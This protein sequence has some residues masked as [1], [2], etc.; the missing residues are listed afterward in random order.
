[1]SKLNET[2]QKVLEHMIDGSLAAT[3]GQFG[4]IDELSASKLDLDPQA[5][6]AYITVLQEKGLVEVHTKDEWGQQYNILAAGW[7]LTTP[8]RNQWADFS[9]EE[10]ADVRRIVKGGTG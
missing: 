6:G 9:D 5:F 2:E 4:H 7:V 10:M 3:G 8:D 1:M